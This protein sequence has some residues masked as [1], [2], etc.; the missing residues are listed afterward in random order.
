MRLAFALGLL[1]ALLVAVL[2]AT[3]AA[4][5]VENRLVFTRPDGTEVAYPSRVRVWC[6][7]WEQDVPVRAIHVQVGVRGEP[8]WRMSAVV[9]DVNR[10]R[11][12]ELPHSFVFDQPTGALL[13]AVDGTNELSSA[14]EEAAGR[15]VFRRA[16]CGRRLSVRF[17]VAATLGSE[18]S[19]GQPVRV[20]GTFTA[21]K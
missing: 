13:F 14:E 9:A 20:R 19:D 21:L 3:A 10:R 11:V 8:Y 18:F 4:I 2:P 16:R 1:A 15:I 17:R 6:G 12:V 7:P 5:T